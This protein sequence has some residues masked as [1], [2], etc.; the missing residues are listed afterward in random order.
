MAFRL[1]TVPIR[2]P[3]V[4]QQELNSFL[5][6]HKILSVDRRW[7]DQGAD[8]FW[9]FCVDYH[10][11]ATK[12]VAA[13]ATGKKSQVDYREVLNEA[14]FNAF[15]ELREL[16]KQVALRENVAVYVVFTNEQLAEMVQ[17]RVAS[18][19]GLE[20]IAGA[21]SARVAKYGDPFLETLSKLWCTQDET[22]RKPSRTDS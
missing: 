15:S 7:V 22:S 9:S 1:F 14:D 17:Q 21:G 10:P 19:A 18:K 20:K 11:T 5:Q 6:S 2:D 3:D 16:R 12:A 8:S 4:A 13:I